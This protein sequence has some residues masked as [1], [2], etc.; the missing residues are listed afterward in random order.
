MHVSISRVADGNDSLGMALQD[1]MMRASEEETRKVELESIW[2][3]A[4]CSSD[5]GHA[6]KQLQ[7]KIESSSSKQIGFRPLL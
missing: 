5:I 1:C 2:T 6:E 3:D 4:F 7:A